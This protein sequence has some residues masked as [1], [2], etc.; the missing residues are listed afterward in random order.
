MLVCKVNSEGSRKISLTGVPAYIM[1]GLSR[2]FTSRNLYLG[3]LSFDH[4]GFIRFTTDL[5]RMEIGR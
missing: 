3:V 5:C 1:I 2:P 4:E